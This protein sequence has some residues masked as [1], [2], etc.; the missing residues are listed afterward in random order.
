MDSPGFGACRHLYLVLRGWIGKIGL[1]GC[2]TLRR[3][4]N[5]SF[6]LVWYAGRVETSQELGQQYC[7]AGFWSWTR[8]FGLACSQ[9]A[10]C[11]AQPDACSGDSSSGLDYGIASSRL[12]G[13]NNG[14]SAMG[15]PIERV[16]R[17]SNPDLRNPIPATSDFLPTVSSTYRGSRFILSDRWRSH[18]DDERKFVHVKR[19]L[20]TTDCPYR[21]VALSTP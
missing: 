3:V 13:F 19:V 2:A 11:L 12:D 4:A 8:W 20:D 7:P 21:P 14:T 1:L 17:L 9:F 15:E 18:S 6:W 16:R 10:G 5:Q